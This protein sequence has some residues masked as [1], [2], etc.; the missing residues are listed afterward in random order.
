MRLSRSLRFSITVEGGYCSNARSMLT[1]IPHFQVTYF[2][3]SST[4]GPLE[5]S[6]G[7]PSIAYGAVYSP[8]S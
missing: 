5:K 3:L 1:Y 8:I 7:G 4:R 6:L 2:I